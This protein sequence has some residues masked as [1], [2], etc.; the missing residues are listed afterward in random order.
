VRLRRRKRRARP[1]E[2]ITPEEFFTRWIPDQVATDEERR[3]KLG[4]T[5]A[6]IGFEIH[7]VTPSSFTVAIEDGRVRGELGAPHEP[8]LRVEVDE[9]DWRAL[10]R[11]DLGAPAALLRRRLSI[12][13]D[14]ALAIKLHFILG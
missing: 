7:G 6:V 12:R 10:N 5:R 13:G 14:L 2:D 1:P 4:D 3:E 11:G 8:D 9:A